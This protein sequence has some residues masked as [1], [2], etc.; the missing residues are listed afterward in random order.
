M[1][2]KIVRLGAGFT[3]GKN[4]T[5]LNKNVCFAFAKPE[6]GGKKPSGKK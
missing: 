4:T 5:Y 1:I 6:G 3:Q 2:K